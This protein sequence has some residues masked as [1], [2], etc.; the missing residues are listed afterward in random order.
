MFG[1][2]NKFIGYS[3]KQSFCK[4]YKEFAIQTKFMKY[5]R[6]YCALVLLLKN[7]VASTSCVYISDSVK[8]CQF[9]P[10]LFLT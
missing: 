2:S 6:A 8:F 9:L 3:Y 10:D 1:K 4:S 5:P 7:L